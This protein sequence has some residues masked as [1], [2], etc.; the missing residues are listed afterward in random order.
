MDDSVYQIIPVLSALV[1]GFVAAWMI[2]GGRAE[3]AEPRRQPEV[4][5]QFPE[6]DG[7]DSA[8]AAGRGALDEHDPLWG[9]PLSTEPEGEPRKTGAGAPANVEALVEEIRTVRQLLSQSDE[10]FRGFADEISALDEAIKRA[11]GRLRLLTRQ[12]RRANPGGEA[13]E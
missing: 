2:W 7:G 10:E 6:P 4:E 9:D 1:F 5:S 13:G 3:R 11:N 8:S 12:I